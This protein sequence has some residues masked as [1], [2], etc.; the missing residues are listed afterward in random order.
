MNKKIRIT[1]VQ[2]RGPEITTLREEM[3]R[4]K[5]LKKI[6]RE[7]MLKLEILGNSDREEEWKEEKEQRPESNRLRRIVVDSTLKV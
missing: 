1:Y 6:E 3:K 7:E 4:K 5:M 2:L